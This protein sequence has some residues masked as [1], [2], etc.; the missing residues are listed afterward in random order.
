MRLRIYAD[1]KGKPLTASRGANG[2]YDPPPEHTSFA[3][4]FDPDSNGHIVWLLQN[5]ADN[6]VI[7]RKTETIFHCGN[8]LVINPDTPRVQAEEELAAAVAAL[9]D[10]NEPIHPA[11][12]LLMRRLCEGAGWI[13]QPLPN[14]GQQ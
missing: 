2:V 13:R 10:P 7:D 1:K 3:I 4:N 11:V 9:D 8:A 6:I 14:T 12:R 5:D